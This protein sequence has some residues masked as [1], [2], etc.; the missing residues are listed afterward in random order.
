M[1]LVGRDRERAAI[2]GALK[3]AASGRRAALIL[4][5]EA[6]IGKS[7]LLDYA[8]SCAHEFTVLRASGVEFEAELPFSTLHQLLMPVLDGRAH[9]PRP[10]ARALEAAFA[11]RDDLAVDRFAVYLATLGLIAAAAGQRPVLCLVDDV[12]WADS[13]SFQAIRF[14]SRRLSAD[15]VALI[16][17]ER[18]DGPRDEF[19]AEELHVSRLDDAAA[20]SLVGRAS[21]HAAP[22]LFM[23]QVIASGDGNP[24]A[25]VEIA[26]ALR[27]GQL[28]GAD[29]LDVDL[30]TPSSIQRLFERRAADL[31]ESGRRAVAI[32]ASSG[33]SDL[34]VIGPAM[35][36]LELGVDALAAAV[37]AGLVRLEAAEV[38][39]C[40]PLMRAAAYHSASPADRRIAHRALAAATPPSSVQ[41]AWHEA[42]AADRPDAAV[43]ERL[44]QAAGLAGR[45][46]GPAAQARMLVVAARLTP[47][48]DR[49]ALRLVAAV[50]ASMAAAQ[51]GEIE[52]WLNEAGALAQDAVVT[53]EV[54]LRVARLLIQRGEGSL[55]L[56]TCDAALERLPPAAN[57]LAG[58]IL[59]LVAIAREMYES[60]ARA[61]DAVAEARRRGVPTGGEADAHLI[62]VEAGL[63]VAGGH[64]LPADLVDRCFGL[65]VPDGVVSPADEVAS[66]LSLIGELDRAREYLGPAMDSQRRLGQLH[67]LAF[68]LDTWA[69]ILL[70]E[71]RLVE[72]Q[73][74]AEESSRICSDVGL[75]LLGHTS[76]GTLAR[77]AATTGNEQEARVLIQQLEGGPGNPSIY[78]ESLATA[79]GRLELSLGQPERCI[80]RL[81][82]ALDTATRL[83]IGQPY[84]LAFVPDLIEALVECDR[85]AM[86]APARDLYQRRAAST[87]RPWAHAMVER[88]QGLLADD[89]SFVDHFR[90]ALELHGQQAPYDIARTQFAFGR[91]LIRAE[92]RDQAID[93]LREAL[94][95]FTSIGATLWAARSRAELELLGDRPA[96]EG[97]TVRD[98]LTPQEV[99]VAM[100][101]AG[102]ATN[103]ETASQLFLSVKTIEYHLRNVYR[104]LGVRSRTELAG[105]LLGNG[106]LVHF[107]SQ[108]SK[109][110]VAR[111]TT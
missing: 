51:R 48:P 98:R 47:D 38:T 5:G 35:G 73:A 31:S 93:S 30:S 83:G 10:Q 63:R 84:L 27:R 29:P 110:P 57:E 3:Q 42:M 68:N 32:I 100:S 34:A 15:A 77:I 36:T 72:A 4:R 86:A 92:R 37:D 105:M 71:G 26:S 109:R 40:H 96:A 66:W 62:S 7:A 87:T 58:S 49:R 111:I 16:I 103:R 94:D 12:Q 90:T 104:K 23:E 76:T 101:V 59:A 67:R 21:G 56:K 88:C 108:D 55:A 52:G 106:G 19:D 28:T 61:L 2:D 17:G 41:R 60:V 99:Q 75:G 44:E 6:G 18:E 1:D 102:G 69:E 50:D 107:A 79:I 81:Q 54:A 33:S 53:G 11:L 78:A 95:G 91:R 13:A 8:A 20:R 25:L 24:L 9:L 65:S 14:A 70:F 85:P 97:L 46:G 89:H 22:S 45:R 82:Q 64:D 43:A 39:F 74:A 80:P